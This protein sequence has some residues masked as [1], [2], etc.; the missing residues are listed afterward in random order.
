MPADSSALAELRQALVIYY[1]STNR[2]VRADAALMALRQA[3]AH[4]FAALS[5]ALWLAEQPGR[6]QDLVR[7][8]LELQT[9]VDRDAHDHAAR[10]ILATLRARAGRTAD[11]ATIL[12]RSSPAL[13]LPGD[14]LFAEHLDTLGAL[15]PA[16]ARPEFMAEMRDLVAAALTRYPHDA[17]MQMR[18]GQ[19]RAAC[20]ES[21]AARQS[22]RCALNLAQSRLVRLSPTQRDALTRAAEAALQTLP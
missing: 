9:T 1:Q 20:N 21:V 2:P 16:S 7:L 17:R 5:A 3:P 15:Y 8:Q 19:A 13:Q 14:Q 12:A 6:D 22:V 4:R 11:G 10:L 18:M